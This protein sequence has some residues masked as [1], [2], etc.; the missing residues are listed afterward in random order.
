VSSLRESDLSEA[1]GLSVA[2]EAIADGAER[3]EGQFVSGYLLGSLAHGGFAPAASD[4][5]VCLVVKDAVTAGA[6]LA[7]L[8]AEA[9]VHPH[10]LRQ[11]LS[12]FWTGRDAL[13]AGRPDGRLP[14]ID[15][16]DL[17]VHGVLMQGHDVVVGLVP[18]PTTE[19]VASTITFISEKWSEDR[20][21][22]SALHHPEPLLERGPR[23]VT[24]P[25]LFPLRFLWT[26]ITGEFGK[27][28]DAAGWY[29]AWDRALPEVSHMFEA[30]IQ[31]RERGE[32]ASDALAVLEAGLV[33]SWLQLCEVLDDHRL[34]RFSADLQRQGA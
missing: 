1:D 19:L 23:A 6:A 16:A 8:S 30:A 25:A 28:T 4:V 22:M 29:Y 12:V 27:V 32:I 26:A 15:H 20:V 14:A 13:L 18:P 11:R 34:T 5:D 10:A 17:I 24:K 9:Q 7:D 21:W 2:R 3:L 31:W 33:P